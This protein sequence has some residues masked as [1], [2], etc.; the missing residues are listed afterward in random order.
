MLKP[1]GATGLSTLDVVI[2]ALQYID[3]FDTVADD[4]NNC[5]LKVISY[6]LQLSI[7]SMP[8]LDPLRHKTDHSAAAAAQ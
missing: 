4:V 5:E 8:T 2:A 1:P 6:K 7:I 3:I